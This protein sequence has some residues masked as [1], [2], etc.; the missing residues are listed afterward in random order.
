MAEVYKNQ[1]EPIK[2]IL[3]WNGENVDADGSVVVTFYDITEDPSIVPPISPTTLITTI[4]ATKIETNIG[5]YQVTLPTNLTDRERKFK[6]IWSYSVGG[7]SASNTTYADVVVPYASIADAVEQLGIG[8]DSGDPQYITYSQLKQAEKYARHI[9]ENYTSQEFNTYDD[10]EIVYG[11]GSNI[12][13]LSYRI[14]NI[15]KLYANDVLLYDATVSPVI[16]NWIYT[17]IVDESSYAIRVNTSS[18]IDNTVYSANGMVPPS[19]NDISNGV[20]AKDV[21]YKVVAKFGWDQVPE[22]VQQACINLMGHYFEKDTVWKDQYVKSLQTFDWSIQYSTEVFA[23][24]GC[25]YADR[26]LAA[27]V[28]SKMVVI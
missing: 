27:Y 21:R 15:Y 10:T 22:D 5:S 16:N 8:V 3:F 9:I 14:Q 6:L 26:L 17:P 12:L 18:L 1:Y 2:N 19:I 23:T 28:L 13:P 11:S 4:V 20:F 24:T 7:I 25:A